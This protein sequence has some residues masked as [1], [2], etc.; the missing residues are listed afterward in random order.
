MK[1]NNEFF[2]KQKFQPLYKNLSIHC[3]LDY[4]KTE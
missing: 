4:R 2:K 1:T 3:A